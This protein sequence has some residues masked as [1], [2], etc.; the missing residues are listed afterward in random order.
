MKKIKTLQTLVIPTIYFGQ[1]ISTE[2][3]SYIKLLKNKNKRKNIKMWDWRFVTL[4]CKYLTFNI[5]LLIGMAYQL[6]LSS[7][8][9]NPPPDGRKGGKREQGRKGGEERGKWW[10]PWACLHGKEDEERHHQTEET[11]S[12]RQ[13]KAQ[14]GVGEELLLQ[15]GVPAEK[16]KQVHQVKYCQL[17]VSLT[18]NKQTDIC[19]QSCR[20][21]TVFHEHWLLAGY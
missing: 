17:N 11:H 13:S 3:R 19:K 21:D 4:C 10:E 1:I 8:S 2:V 18:T 5:F 7:R 6:I 14:D 15:G 16:D 20:A 9:G 12:L